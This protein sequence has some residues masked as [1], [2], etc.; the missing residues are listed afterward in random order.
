[1]VPVSFSTRN[2]GTEGSLC[3]LLPPHSSLGSPV[4]LVHHSIPAHCVPS[5]HSVEYTLGTHDML[6]EQR[7]GH[8]HLPFSFLSARYLPIWGYTPF[9]WS[10]R[11]YDSILDTTTL[12]CQ[13]CL[14]CLFLFSSHV[15]AKVHVQ[16]SKK[17]RFWEPSNDHLRK[18]KTTICCYYPDL[19]ISV[20]L[21][22]DLEPNT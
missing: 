8:L 14:V 3:Q 16:Y 19:M 18:S 21:I 10:V 4:Y 11:V 9:L 20:K 17:L 12:S 13:C 1:M 2:R 15:T 22:T 6:V 5:Q 7:P